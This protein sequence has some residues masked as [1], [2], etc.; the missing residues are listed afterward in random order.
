GETGIRPS[1]RPAGSI[2]LTC[3]LPVHASSWGS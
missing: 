2:A 3:Y 1:R